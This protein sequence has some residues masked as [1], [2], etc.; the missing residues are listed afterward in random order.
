MVA[1]LA[2]SFDPALAV[3]SLTV[4]G[5]SWGTVPAM[6]TI[7]RQ[8]PGEAEEEVRGWHLATVSGGY[9][10]AADHEMELGQSYTYSV[11]GY[12]AADVLLESATAVVDTTVADCAVFLKAPGRP[13]LTVRAQIAQV[14]EISS[15]TVGGN[16]KIRGGSSVAVSQWGGIDP[17][18]TTLVIR[19]DAGVETARLRALLKVARILL[20]QPVG[21]SELDAGWYFC[22]LASRSNPGGFVDFGHRLT[23]LQVEGTRVPAGQSAGAVWTWDMLAATYETWGD[24]AAAYGSWFTVEQGPA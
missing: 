24:V 11:R 1:V 23:P 8:A 15:P 9:V 16:Y 17:D 3:V 19:T 6:V 5:G 21:G 2:A 18:S 10:V 4:D 13:D 14:S 20:I 22:A 12:S 7:V